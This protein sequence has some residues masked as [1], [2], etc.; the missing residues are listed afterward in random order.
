LVSP[1]QHLKEGEKG[2]G[3]VMAKSHLS[4]S[5]FL[6]WEKKK[7]KREGE[8]G[9][10]GRWANSTFTTSST[11]SKGRKRKKGEGEEGRAWASFIFFIPE[12]GG[13]KKRRGGGEEIPYHL[14]FLPLFTK[15]KKGGRERGATPGG[16]PETLA[17]RGKGKKKGGP[18]ITNALGCSSSRRKKRKGKKGKKAS[19]VAR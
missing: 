17:L 15:G 5:P 12:G 19:M 8:G 9:G 6:S 13:E 16:R 10:G 3:G 2:R 11:V 14:C 18:D 7:K 4:F 1:P